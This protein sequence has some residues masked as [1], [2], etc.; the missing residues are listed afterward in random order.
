MNCEICGKKTKN[1]HKIVIEGAVIHVCSD[2]KNLG[3][4]EPE[5]RIKPK[6][7]GITR[8]TKKIKIKRREKSFAEDEELV[9]DY[10]LIIK[11]EREK[12]GWSQ[13]ELAKKLMEKE[14]LIKKIENA[15]IIP[16]PKV[17][18]KI[19]KLFGIKLREKTYELVPSHKSSGERFDLTLGD[20]ATVKRK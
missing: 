9:E 7:T 10:N 5:L 16:E 12:R 3:V 6:I 14:S 17:I 8:K 11:R 2:C 20:I 18:E 1:I 15:E 4:P 19:E 13:E